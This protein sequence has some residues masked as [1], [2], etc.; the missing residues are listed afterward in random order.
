M[1]S[2]A[3]VSSVTERVRTSLFYVPTVFLVAGAVLG[4]ISVTVDSIVSR[5]AAHLPIG[6]T[7]TV[8]S[9]RTVLGTIAGATITVAGI[10]FSVSLLIIQL[11]SSQYS[12]RVIHGL[13]RD[14]FN[15]RVMG[16]VVGT[17]TYCLIVLRSVRAP[18]EEGDTPV[19]PNISVAIAVVLGLVA[20]LSIIGF[21]NHSAHS[22]DVS[23][24]L[25]TVTD[26]AIAQIDRTWPDVDE[27]PHES[28]GRDVPADPPF[29]VDIAT[30][31]WV[32]HI[33]R[34]GLIDLVP[35]GG[36]VRL[37]TAVGRYAIKGMPLCTLWPAPPAGDEEA[38]VEAAHH[39]VAIGKTRTL[40]QDVTYGVR[41]L[42]D[43]AL[44]ALSP[45][46]NDPTTAQD[47]IFHM[48]AVLAELL[49]RPA[50]S[51]SFEDDHGRR[52]VD[53]SGDAHREVIAL[54]FDELRHFSANQPR[55]AV[56]LLQSLWSLTR[57]LEDAGHH[58]RAAPLREQARL[59]V[60]GTER[61]G[62]LAHDLATVNDAYAA[63]FTGGTVAR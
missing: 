38:V 58:V 57:L 12:P 18:I 49:R 24:I 39:A 9:A 41:Q 17:F 47:A 25:Q 40:S 28:A 50:P 51:P 23:Q 35:P 20:I 31:G 19:I 2:V 32:Q 63:R 45:G 44:K 43:V 34:H 22:M 21:I 27:P 48:T 56:Y 36:T 61:A 37:E 11:A 5:G 10:A 30:N 62:L 52:L 4:Q 6:L 33:D 60:A 59:V 54:A 42:A 1:S 55:L 46:I 13:F 16:V 29:R 53:D 3:R 26:E 14:P 7:S 15:K 8:E